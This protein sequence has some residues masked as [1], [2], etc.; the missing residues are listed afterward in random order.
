VIS[1]HLFIKCFNR[2]EFIDDIIPVQYPSSVGSVNANENDSNIIE[3]EI[4]NLLDKKSHTN[5]C[6]CE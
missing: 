2:P 4:K 5:S 1:S 6:T 3:A